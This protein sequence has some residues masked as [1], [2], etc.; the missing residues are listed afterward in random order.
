MRLD[1]DWITANAQRRLGVKLVIIRMRT[2]RRFGECT[3]WGA[4]W[5]RAGGVWKKRMCSTRSHW[6]P[7]AKPWVK[8]SV[9]SCL[10]DGTCAH[11]P[12][13]AKP[14]VKSSVAVCRTG[15]WRPSRPSPVR[16]TGPTSSHPFP[17]DRG[18]VWQFRKTGEC[19]FQWSP[20][21]GRLYGELVQRASL[22]RRKPDHASLKPIFKV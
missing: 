15:P 10:P 17:Q 13:L 11:S 21:T 16:Q 6:Q 18:T 4:R 14:W 9:G 2:A 20:Q 8:S 3:V 1:I 22:Q 7:L 19:R 12:P 5:A